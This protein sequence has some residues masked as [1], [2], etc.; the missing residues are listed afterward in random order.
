MKWLP[1]LAFAA[2]APGVTTQ[3]AG[4]AT[5]Y[6]EIDQGS[7]GFGADHAPYIA[8]P[9]EWMMGQHARVCG[10]YVQVTSQGA[11]GPNG[12]ATCATGD[13]ITFEVTDTCPAQGN[14]RWCANPSVA[15]FDLGA[16][17]FAAL[18]TPACGVLTGLTWQWVEMPGDAPLRI[19][20]K[21]GVN[22][23]WYAFFVLDHRSALARAEVR[24][25]SGDAWLEARHQSYNAWV[26]ENAKSGFVPPL[27]IRLTDLHGQVVTLENVVTS[28]AESTEFPTTQQFPAGKGGGDPLSLP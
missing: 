2:C 5:F 7:C 9:A 19:R 4:R 28:L 25:S 20:S 6:E 24:D 17:A 3:D 18:G 15:H 26:V 21:D 12:D 11:V 23:W 13:T 14:E 22:A 1:L 16:A 8:A 10:A 27:S